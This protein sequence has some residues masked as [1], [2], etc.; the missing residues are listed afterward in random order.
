MTKIFLGFF[1]ISTLINS[2][3]NGYCLPNNTG[4]LIFKV[5]KKKI[6]L[7]NFHLIKNHFLI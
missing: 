7:Y 4:T 1:F 5:L 2:Q 6:K 3:E